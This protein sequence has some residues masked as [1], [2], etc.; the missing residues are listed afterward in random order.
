M[1]YLQRWF[2]WRVAGVERLL[3]ICTAVMLALL[4]ASQLLM[5]NEEVRS[6]ISRVDFLEGIPYRGPA[7]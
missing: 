4:L 5:M 2:R 7:D 1:N 3:F 6:F